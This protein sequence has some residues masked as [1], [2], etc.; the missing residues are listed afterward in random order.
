[1]HRQRLA[2]I[3]TIIGCCLTGLVALL[4]AAAIGQDAAL[5][6]TPIYAIQGDGAATP[7]RLQRVNSAGVVTAVGPRGFFMQDAVGDGRSETSDGIY[8][9]TSRAPQV[10]PGQCV[11]VRNG[12][13]DEYYDKTELVDADAVEPSDRCAPGMPAAAALPVP[14]F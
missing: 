5:P 14:Q 11:V 4:P 1:M 10:T 12:R 3:R 9:Y 2:D 8:V 7:L 13:V 6:L